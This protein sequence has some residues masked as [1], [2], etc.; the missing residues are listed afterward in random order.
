MALV[1][2]LARTSNSMVDLWMDFFTCKHSFMFQDLS[3]CPTKLL[4]SSVTAHLIAHLIAELI[5]L[6]LRPHDSSRGE[7]VE[8]GVLIPHPGNRCQDTS[9]INTLLHAQ[10]INNT[11]HCSICTT[12]L[13]RLCSTCVQTPQLWQT[14]QRDIVHGVQYTYSGLCT[15]YSWTLSWTIPVYRMYIVCTQCVLHNLC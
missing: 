2:A 5:I 9:R 8:R 12:V 1:D 6:C 3:K 4:V 14:L 15:S 13:I 11:Q 7:Q 10:H